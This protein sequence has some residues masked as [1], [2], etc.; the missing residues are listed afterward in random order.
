M[1][2]AEDT[3]TDNRG[4]LVTGEDGKPTRW[5]AALT[6]LEEGNSACAESLAELR[7]AF[8]ELASRDEAAD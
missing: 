8:E 4:G 1:T 6:A 2:I 3:A 7:E 5:E